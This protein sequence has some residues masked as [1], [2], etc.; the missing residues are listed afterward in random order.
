MHVS[1]VGHSYSAVS[2]SDFSGTTRPPRRPS[3]AVMSIVAP[4]SWIRSRSATALKPPKTTEW[5]API[6]AQASMAMASSG[7]IGR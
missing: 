1:T 5:I 4:Q 2:A 6:R 3:S 7:I